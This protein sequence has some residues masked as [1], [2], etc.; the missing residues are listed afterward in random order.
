[1][2]LKGNQR[3]GAKDLALHLMK[4]E[5]EH[6]ELHELRGFAAQTLMG[7]LNEAYAVSRGTRCKQFLYS[8]SLNP[9]KD[10]SVSIADFENAIDQAEQRLNLS[11]QPRAIVFHEKEGRRHA[12]VVWSRIDASAMKAVQVSYDRKRLTALSRE[13]FLHHGWR[14]PEGLIDHQSRDPRNFTHA[15]WQQAKR[16]G[17]DPR[18]IKAAFQDAWAASDSRVAFIHALEDQGYFVARG[19]R[20]GFVA[21]DIHGEVYSIPKQAGVKTKDVRARLG[22][23]NALPSVD[24]VKTQIARDM[25]SKFDAFRDEL[26]AEADKHVSDFE[27]RRL[28]L[29]TRQRAER[30]RLNERQDK[31]RIVENRKRQTRFRKG[32]KGVWDR[33]RGEHRRIRKQ[34][35]REAEATLARDRAEKDRLIRHHL[36]QRQKLDLFKLRLRR[37]HAVRRRKLERDKQHFQDMERP[38]PKRPEP[39]F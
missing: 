11:G 39:E 38:G 20:R 1:M 37:D 30:Q 14:M 21:V 29:V 4:P 8:L 5:N 7:A 17:T 25:L 35:E 28:N 34:N 3:G 22:D 15:E 27:R 26:S 33:L 10:E 13:L 24:A 6:V 19:D 31:R 12:H 2:I 9:P 36:E 23:E 32:L 18:A 16:A